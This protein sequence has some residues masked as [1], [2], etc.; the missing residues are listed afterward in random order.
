MGLSTEE[1]DKLKLFSIKLSRDQT[2]AILNRKLTNIEWKLINKDYKKIFTPITKQVARLATS[3][4]YLKP[5]YSQ[6]KQP[7]PINQ[8][9]YFQSIFKNVVKEASI[10]GNSRIVR[11]ERNIKRNQNENE[12]DNFQFI[13]SLHKKQKDNYSINKGQTHNKNKYQTTITEW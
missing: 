2:E 7:R 10:K 13:K 3:K 6:Y 1:K 4:D 5:T 11:L 8:S 9:T 12:L